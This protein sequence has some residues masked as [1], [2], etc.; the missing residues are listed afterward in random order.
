VITL[1]PLT[2]LYL[3]GL[4]V[5]MLTIVPKVCGFKPG[6]KDGFLR[7]IEIR[8][9]TTYGGEVKPTAIFRKI[10]R[11]VKEPCEV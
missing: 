1:L 7:A 4:V 10:L 5:I 2:E 11:Q 6:H 8:R 9:S 3:F